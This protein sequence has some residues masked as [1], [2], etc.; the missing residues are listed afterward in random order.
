MILEQVGKF[1]DW[2]ALTPISQTIQN[3]QWIIPMVQ[4]VHIIAIAIVMSSM[5]MVDL[6]LM[7]LVG[8][9]QP[10]SGVARRF[11][12]WVW[13]SLVVLLATGVVLITAE[14]RRDLLNPVFQ[15]K[16]ALLIVAMMVTVFFQEMV[17]RNMAFWDQS[18]G[19]RASAWATAIV[20]L[21]VLAAIIACGRWIAYVE[22]G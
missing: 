13:W 17:R 6:R 2:L 18:S 1:C 21:L 5:I 22:H 14:P 19:R 11:V 8:S 12:P 15:A 9:S 4:S 7:G 3:V 20:S 16:M 10:I